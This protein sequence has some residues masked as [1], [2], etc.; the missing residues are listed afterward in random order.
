MGVDSN[1]YLTTTKRRRQ[2][3]RC[4]GRASP[5]HTRLSPGCWRALWGLLAL[6]CLRHV[7]HGLDRYHSV[8]RVARFAPWPCFNVGVLFSV[9]YRGFCLCAPCCQAHVNCHFA[10]QPCLYG[11]A[12]PVESYPNWSACEFYCLCD[13]LRPIF[14]ARLVDAVSHDFK[15]AQ[16]ET[17]HVRAT[18]DHCTSQL[19]DASVPTNTQFVAVSPRSRPF[20]RVLFLELQPILWVGSWPVCSSHYWRLVPASRYALS[21]LRCGRCDNHLVIASC[22]SISVDQVFRPCILSTL[23]ILCP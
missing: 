17:F 18:T 6:I 23:L 19:S 13:P 4:R 1:G 12:Y 7:D 9:L 20:I 5:K 22:D 10:Y 8:C 2:K 16:A 14:C 3:Q 11:A 15:Q 21:L